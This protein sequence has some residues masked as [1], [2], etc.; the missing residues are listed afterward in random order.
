M[1][2]AIIIIISYIIEPFVILFFYVGQI[3]NPPP[4]PL[5]ISLEYQM[6]ISN[7]SDVCHGSCYLSS[8]ARKQLGTCRRHPPEVVLT[9]R[10]LDTCIMQGRALGQE[11]STSHIISC[12]SE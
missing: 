1:A 9:G 8:S 5:H 11:S 3:Q 2:I 10:Y 6:Q 12:N 4:H 7:V